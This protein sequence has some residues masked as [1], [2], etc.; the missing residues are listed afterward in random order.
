MAR[1]GVGLV[2][3]FAEGPSL[4]SR[5]IDLASRNVLPAVGPFPIGLSGRGSAVST[6]TPGGAEGPAYAVVETAAADGLHGVT[7]RPGNSSPEVRPLPLPGSPGVLPADRALAWLP[8]DALALAVNGP[9]PRLMLLDTQWDERASAVLPGGLSVGVLEVGGTLV[10]ITTT[11]V[12]ELHLAR[13]DVALNPTAP[14]R[15]LEPRGPLSGP[16]TIGRTLR[17]IVVI[18]TTNG[19]LEAKQ[20]GCN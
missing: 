18:R 4:V 16:V 12:G 10:A 9:T 19:A 5:Q 2:A 1:W 17:H 8:P 13:F 15:V 7:L 3:L 20:I 14:F 11:A 6:S